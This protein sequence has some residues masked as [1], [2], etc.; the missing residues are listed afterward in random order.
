MYAWGILQD[1][2]EYHVLSTLKMDIETDLNIYA[3]TSLCHV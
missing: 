1:F 3:F 2:T